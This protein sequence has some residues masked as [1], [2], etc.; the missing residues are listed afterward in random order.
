MSMAL[1]ALLQN[2]YLE[3]KGRGNLGPGDEWLCPLQFQVLKNP[4]QDFVMMKPSVH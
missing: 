4:Y 1:V 2:C 3:Y